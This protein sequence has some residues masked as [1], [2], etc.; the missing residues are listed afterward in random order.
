MQDCASSHRN[1]D[2]TQSTSLEYLLDKE[3]RE[4]EWKERHNDVAD[5]S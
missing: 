5:L 3:A 2:C 4:T 1:I